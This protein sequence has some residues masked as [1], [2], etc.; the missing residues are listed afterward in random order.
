MKHYIS[1][2]NHVISTLKKL[3]KEY[4]K[5]NSSCPNTVNSPT[6]IV[7]HAAFSIY[8]MILRPLS[9]DVKLDKEMLNF[10]KT[11]SKRIP[12]SEYPG[13]ENVLIA[14]DEVF[15]ESLKL[16]K[17]LKNWNIKIPK[18]LET[19]G[20]FSLD[21]LI[22]HTIQDIAYH[23]GQISYLNKLLKKEQKNK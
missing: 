5:L 4:I 22:T 20:F 14:L 17:D 21:N 13:I 9:S 7:G 2:L 3:V 11:G 19:E 23:N 18:D 15:N 8:D 12:E 6:W 10:F 1:E 16:L